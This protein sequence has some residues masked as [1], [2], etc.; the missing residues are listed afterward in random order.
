M[1]KKTY[2]ISFDRIN[3]KGRGSYDLEDIFLWYLLFIKMYVSNIAK[4]L[5]WTYSI[6]SGRNFVTLSDIQ[7]HSI[8]KIDPPRVELFNQKE[9]FVKIC[10]KASW[11]PKSIIFYLSGTD[12]NNEII[13]ESKKEL[14][15]FLE[16]LLDET[17]TNVLVFIKKGGPG[18]GGGYDVIPMVIYPDDNTEDVIQRIEDKCVNINKDKRYARNI[19][20]LQRGIDNPLLTPRKQKTDF[21]FHLLAVGNGNGLIVFYASKTGVMRNTYQYPY[22]PWSEDTS[23]QITNISQN[24]SKVNGKLSYIMN[25]FDK[26]YK[27]LYD[28]IMTQIYS[29]SSDIGKFYAPIFSSDYPFA[30]VLGIDCMVDKDSLKVYVIE[31]NRRPTIYKPWE[32]EELKYESIIFMK[33]AFRLGVASLVENNMGFVEETDSMKMVHRSMEKIIL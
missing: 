12:Q 29:I 23:I 32:A 10:K 1:L 3:K 31:L 7:K 15:D 16:N 27:S 8:I 14:Y 18:I 5:K 4:K 26:K 20:I 22:D 13:P 30:S 25:T 21:R 28:P 17:D 9:N 6:S 11:I 2:D 33:D 19:F 24:L